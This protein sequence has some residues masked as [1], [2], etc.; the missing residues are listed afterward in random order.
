M[1]IVLLYCYSVLVFS[2]SVFFLSV[3][4]CSLYLFMFTLLVLRHGTCILLCNFVMYV[5]FLVR[6]IECMSF[7]FAKTATGHEPS[8]S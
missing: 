6:C 7:F 4:Y 2:Y 8:C 1:F 3:L 5:L